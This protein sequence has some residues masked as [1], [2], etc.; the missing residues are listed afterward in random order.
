MRRPDFPKRIILKR[1]VEK[2]KDLFISFKDLENGFD[3]VDWNDIWSV[4]QLYEVRR[5][6]VE[7][8]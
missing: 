5:R 6:L 7:A 8:A 1:Y 2:R 4:L 3:R